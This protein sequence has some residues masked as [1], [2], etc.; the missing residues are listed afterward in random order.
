MYVHMSGRFAH[1]SK[2]NGANFV[3]VQRSWWQARV[4]EA[5]CPAS[6]R[7]GSWTFSI[8]C[9]K[10][11]LI[12]YPSCLNCGPRSRLLR[13]SVLRLVK[14]PLCDSAE[15]NSFFFLLWCLRPQKP[16]GLLGT[17]EEWDRECEPRPASLFTQLLSSVFN[18]LSFVTFVSS[19]GLMQFSVLF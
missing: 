15:F 12:S 18:S 5:G 14:P 13:F 1:K 17:G 2:L 11:S 6:V 19:S 16:Y 10:K 4:R 7:T 3:R 8:S 9:L